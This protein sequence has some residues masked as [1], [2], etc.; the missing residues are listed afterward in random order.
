MTTPRLTLDI[1]M[2]LDGF[3]AGPDGGDST[4][5]C[6]VSADSRF[7][8]LGEGEFRAIA[9]RLGGRTTRKRRPQR[10]RPWN[11]ASSAVGGVAAPPTRQ[12]VSDARR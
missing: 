10:A 8:Q 3:V 9:L 11:Q 5:S 1:T 12:R 6:V 2:S 4:D 7:T